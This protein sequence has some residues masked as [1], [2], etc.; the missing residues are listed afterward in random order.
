MRFFLRPVSSL[1]LACTAVLAD[2]PAKPSMAAFTAPAASILD[3]ASFAQWVGR[4]ESPLGEIKQG[5]QAAFWTVDLK[6]D[7][8]GVKFGEGRE[9]GVRHLRIGL[10][11]ARAI[12]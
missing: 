1:V 3:K 8:R 7:F 4:Q 12:G 6:L 5:P 9:T 10:T 11:D 2:E